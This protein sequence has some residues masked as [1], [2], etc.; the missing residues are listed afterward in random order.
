M[1]VSETTVAASI[2]QQFSSCGGPP[3]SEVTVTCGY[4][5]TFTTND[6]EPAGTISYTCTADGQPSAYYVNPATGAWVAQS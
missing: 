5:Y 3:I 4:P 2:R 6:A 1:P